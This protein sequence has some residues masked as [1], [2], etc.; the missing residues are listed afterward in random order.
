[1]K[2]WLTFGSISLLLLASCSSNNDP[3][4]SFKGQSAKVIFTNGEIAMAKGNYDDAAKN[5]EALDALY[6]FG[7]YA[8]KA[9]LDLIYTYYQNDDAP[10]AAAAAGRYIHMYPTTKN[11]DYAMYMKGLIDFTQGRS[12]LQKAVGVS[13]V[14]RDLSHFKDAYLDFAQLTQTFPK[15]QYAANAIVRM[16]YIRNII[17]QYNLEIGQFY[18]DRKAYV[19]SANRAAKVIEHFQGAPA[20]VPAMAMLV[21]SYRNLHQTVLADKTLQAFAA[22]FPNATQYKKLAH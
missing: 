14:D 18:Y 1:M 12:W 9:Q 11:V 2:K 20:T 5:F 6:P 3:Y 13:P 22:A 10:N 16:R 7:P 19:A 17:A 21:D 8:Q 4:A 15:S